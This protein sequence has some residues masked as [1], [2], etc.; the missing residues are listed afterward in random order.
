MPRHQA[1]CPPSHSSV[2]GRDVPH[3]VG[4][5][6]PWRVRAASSSLGWGSCS[7]KGGRPAT[8]SLV[9]PFSI[10]PL[11]TGFSLCCYTHSVCPGYCI[12]SFPFLSIP[13]LLSLPALHPLFLGSLSHPA[14]FLPAYL[15]RSLP[16]RCLLPHTGQHSGGK[17]MLAKAGLSNNK[18]ETLTK[19]F[20]LFLLRFTALE[21][22]S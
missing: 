4:A 6:C 21:S 19:P 10:L 1:F 15:S 22:P 16:G 14:L 12:L 13:V 2:G 5:I 7:S 3:C 20:L 9:G 11:S 8:C 18:T 17:R